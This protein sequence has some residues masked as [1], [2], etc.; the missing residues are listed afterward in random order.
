MPRPP[1]VVRLDEIGKWEMTYVAFSRGG[2]LVCLALATAKMA[3]LLSYIL[4]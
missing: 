1:R 2:P 4:K 3:E